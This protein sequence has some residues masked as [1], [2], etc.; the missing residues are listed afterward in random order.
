ML[1]PDDAV[2]QSEIALG[3]QGAFRELFEKHRAKLYNY[4]YTVVKSK[5]IAEEIVIDVFLKIWTGRELITEIRNMDAFLHKVAYNK[6]LDFFRIASRNAA[7]QKLI[8]REME[9]AR[10][11]QA[12]HRLQEWEC[13]EIINRALERLSPQRRIIFT[14]SRMEGL[15]Y[16]QI[17]EKLHLSRNTVR[18][19]MAETLRSLRSYLKEHEINAV[20][21]LC[22]LVSR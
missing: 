2:L 11:K 18:N 6:A 13:K 5:E 22:F 1:M 17:A 3:N 15:S 20:L 10:E 4:L 12:D 14:L 7:L 21:L 9:E 8:R 19:T 16:D